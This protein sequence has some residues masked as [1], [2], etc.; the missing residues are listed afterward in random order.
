MNLKRP[1]AALELF[2]V[3]PATL[4]M[5]ALFLRNVQPVPYEPAQT[6][7]HLVDWFA[8]RPQIGLGLFLIALPFLAFVIGA[9]TML[10][11]WRGDPQLRQTAFSTLAAVRAHLS[12][13]LIAAATFVA[14]ATL[15]IVALHMISD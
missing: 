8:A 3:L 7:R 1:L 15:C 6:A 11:T 2:L 10:R 9:A 13:L 4:F 5:L 12:T 14:G